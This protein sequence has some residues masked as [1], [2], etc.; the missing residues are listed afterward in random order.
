M[1]SFYPA[2]LDAG[3]Y[4]PPGYVLPA[5]HA[6]APRPADSNINTSHIYTLPELI[7]IAQS[8]NPST[9]RAW[10]AARDAALAVGIARTTYV[11]HLTAS[12]VGGMAPGTTTT[13]LVLKTADWLATLSTTPT[14]HAPRITGMV[15]CKR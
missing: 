5:N 2:R 10:N 3:A 1:G 14:L 12:I 9:R 8:N 13:P 6:L 4:A 15:K 11:P 7:D